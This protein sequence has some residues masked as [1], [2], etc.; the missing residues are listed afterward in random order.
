MSVNNRHMTLLFSVEDSFFIPGKG[1]VVSGVNPSFD[2]ESHEDI[3]SIIG[4]LVRIHIDNEVDRIG[5]VLDVGV[6]ESL[7]GKK[8]ISILLADDGLGGIARGATVFAAKLARGAAGI[9]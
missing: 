9:D 4:G 3:V 1:I 6:G 2:G 5:N 7:T 8:N